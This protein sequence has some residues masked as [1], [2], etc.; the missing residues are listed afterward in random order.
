MSNPAPA[1]SV[2]GFCPYCGHDNPPQYRFCLACRR[3]LPELPRPKIPKIEVAGPAAAGAPSLEGNDPA[4]GR[5]PAVGT[6]PPPELNE[7][8]P[9]RR[10]GPWILLPIAVVVIVVIA[11][12]GA[13]LLPIYLAGHP[14]TRTAPPVAGMLVSLC[15]PDNGSDCKGYAFSLPTMVTGRPANTTACDPFSSLGPSETLWMNYTADANI[16]AIVLPASVFGG[17]TGWADNAWG[18]VH[19]RTALAD[20]LWFS[21]LTSGAF[22][23]TIPVPDNGGGYCIG[24]W[25]PSPAPTS[26]TWLDNV[27]VTYQ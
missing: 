19:N 11:L 8:L 26:V 18:Q 7:S 9:A 2:P 15:D 21:N 25:E 3:R 14:S 13:Q 1:R 17:P 23:G 16:Y 6:E 4:G 22:S 20:A 5:P 10:G 12:V 27:T 24:W